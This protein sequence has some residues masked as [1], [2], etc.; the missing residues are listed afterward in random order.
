MTAILCDKTSDLEFVNEV[1]KKLF[2]KKGKTM[3][4]LPPTRMHYCNTQSELHIKQEYGAPVRRVNNT[5]LLQKVGAELS[6]KTV[7]HGSLCGTCYLRLPK[8]ALN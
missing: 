5:H 4:T 7:S 2:C 3:K 6:M 8:P 1:R